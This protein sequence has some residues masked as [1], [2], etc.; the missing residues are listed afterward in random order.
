MDPQK[1]RFLKLLGKGFVVLGSGL[2]GIP[3]GACQRDPGYQELAD[4]GPD[5]LTDARLEDMTEAEIEA[6]VAEVDARA[7]EVYGDAPG[8][9]PGPEDTSDDGIA[10]G[11]T[12]GPDA[13]V[14]PVIPPGQHVVES[15][16]SL[17]NNP[18]PRSLEDWTFY[19]EGEVEQPLE[20]TWE[21]FNALE[22]VEQVINHHCVTGWTMLNLPTRGVPLKALLAMAGLTDKANF[23]VF[24]C[25]H[26]Y[27]TNIHIA[28][29][30]KDNVQIE[31]GMWGE[32]LLDKYGGPA[33][34]RVPDLYG[35]KSGKWVM[36]LRILEVDEPGFWETKGY[37]NT[38]D[39]WTQDRY[40]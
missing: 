30:Q 27:T 7:A 14:S 1:R 26:G 28:E 6:F 37:S 24:D 9:T 4:M 13:P 29:A 33:R 32:A 10:P 15:L 38:A 36:G 21:E 40:S 19:V 12:E 31:L 22:Q 3:L 17:G 25:E 18:N 11:D 20:F 2:V 8:D 39:P 23:V 35:Y 5:L 16:P 34:G